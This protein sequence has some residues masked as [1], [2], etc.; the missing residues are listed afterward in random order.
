MSKPIELPIEIEQE[1][2]T[3]RQSGLSYSKILDRLKSKGATE[4][5]IKRICKG[6]TV[7]HS[8]NETQAVMEISKLATRE[9]GVKP[10]EMNQ[11]LFEIYGTVWDNKKERNVL[12]L[13]QKDKNTIKRKVNSRCKSLGKTALFTPEWLQVN[14]VSQCKDTFFEAAQLLHETLTQIEMMYKRD[15][16]VTDVFPVSSFVYYVCSV[17]IKS[18]APEGNYQ[19]LEMILGKMDR[20]EDSVDQLELEVSVVQNRPEFYVPY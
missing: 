16:G 4:R 2:I 14:H 10:S 1:A 6:V 8:T 19:R 13:P 7:V 20:V 12:N 15:T 3:L 18:M 17:N 9:V 11:V 5:W